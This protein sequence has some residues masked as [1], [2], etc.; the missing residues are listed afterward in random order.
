MRNYNVRCIFTL[1]SKLI[2]KKTVEPT[3]DKRVETCRDKLNTLGVKSARFYFAL[4]Y[5]EYRPKDKKDIQA[6]NRI[7]N[8]W[9][10]KIT[11]EDFTKKL[12]AFTTFKEVQFKIK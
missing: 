6:K 10:G 9:Y 1:N 5:P 4:K 8:L 12:E 11:D 3:L 2:M 7:D